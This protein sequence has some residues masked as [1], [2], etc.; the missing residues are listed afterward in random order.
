MKPTALTTKAIAFLLAGF[1][2][3]TSCTSYTTIQSVP[4][5]KLWI[6]DVPV[7]T[8][9]YEHSDTK[10]VGSRT[11]VKLEKE[12][13]ETLNTSFSRDEQLDTGA[14]IAGI[15]LTVPFLWIM[16]YN[17]VR[18]YELQPID[19][20]KHITENQI[21]ENKELVISKSKA[22][23]I[24]ELKQLEDEGLISKEEFEKGKKKIL[25]E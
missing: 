21:A 22:E 20:A 3:F 12:G 1:I 11:R 23:R 14:L 24:R 9:P 17:P 8:T 19:P 16:K 5:A 13:Y 4:D 25:D 2:F 15:F 10:I 18:V 6:D 7:G